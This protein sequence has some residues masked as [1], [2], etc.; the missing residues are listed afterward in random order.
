M[1]CDISAYGFLDRNRS[2]CSIHVLILFTIIEEINFKIFKCNWD[3]SLRCNEEGKKSCGKFCTR[4]LRINFTQ[5]FSDAN[6]KF[7]HV[8]KVNW[9]RQQIYSVRFL[10]TRW[11]CFSLTFNFAQENGIRAYVIFCRQPSHHHQHNHH[12]SKRKRSNVQ[13]CANTSDVVYTIFGIEINEKNPDER[14][15]GYKNRDFIMVLFVSHSV[16]FWNDWLMFM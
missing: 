14:D 16:W 7:P 3:A 10:C 2:F 8:H 11:S 6:K 5:K 12:R 4:I 13:S 9:S 1:K 15:H